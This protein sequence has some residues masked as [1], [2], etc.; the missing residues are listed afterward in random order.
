MALKSMVGAGVLLAACVALTSGC[1]NAPARRTTTPGFVQQ[2][3][4][5]MH[6]PMAN[7]YSQPG[8]S[9]SSVTPA[10]GLSHTGGT[11]APSQ[12]PTVANSNARTT[13][14]PFIPASGP[15]PGSFNSPPPAPV[16][17]NQGN[18]PPA[19]PFN[20]MSTPM[21]PPNPAAP[22]TFR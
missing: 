8:Q 10:H 14:Q 11:P 12:T 22:G 3:P 19:A 16:G 21:P 1:Q 4:G 15:G 20:P 6:P 13:Q 7:A 2:K 9:P 5:T 17:F 18:P